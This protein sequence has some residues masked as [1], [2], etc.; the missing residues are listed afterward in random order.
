MVAQRHLPQEQDIGSGEKGPGQ[1]DTEKIIEQV[2]QRPDLH[3]PAP[4]AEAPK[5]PSP[6]VPDAPP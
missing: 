3:R 2:S 6:A 5:K 4:P 1:K